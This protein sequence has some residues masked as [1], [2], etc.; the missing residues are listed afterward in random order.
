MNKK[1]NEY[2]QRRR[3]PHRRNRR[4]RGSGYWT[5]AGRFLRAARK[6][7]KLTASQRAAVHAARTLL[8]FT[9]SELKRGMNQKHFYAGRPGALHDELKHFLDV[10]GG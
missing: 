7:D 1:S 2:D 4:R 6:T 8:A 3:R 10:F 5:R 9:R